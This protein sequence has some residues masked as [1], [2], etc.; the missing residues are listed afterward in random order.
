MYKK[1]GLNDCVYSVQTSFY[2]MSY[3]TLGW[4]LHPE[5]RTDLFVNQEYDQGIDD[6]F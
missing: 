4:L 3:D 1:R 6:S 5:Y 2:I